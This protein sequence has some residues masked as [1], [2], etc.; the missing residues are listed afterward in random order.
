M[1]LLEVHFDQGKFFVFMCCVLAAF[2]PYSKH[3]LFFISLFSNRYRYLHTMKKIDCRPASN[4]TAQTCCCCSSK[5]LQK[6]KQFA[7]LT[8]FE[9]GPSIFNDEIQVFGFPFTCFFPLPNYLKMYLG[10]IVFESMSFD[11]NSF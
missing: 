7:T 5:R 3:I 10:I 8:D 2:F 4:P 1:Y 6:S 9:E 11:F